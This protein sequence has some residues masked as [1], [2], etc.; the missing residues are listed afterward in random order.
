M[1]LAITVNITETSSI[2]ITLKTIG[3]NHFDYKQRTIFG[4]I[5][6]AEKR[7]AVKDTVITQ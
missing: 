1:P 3:A 7:R 5:T 4:S 6:T 2:Q